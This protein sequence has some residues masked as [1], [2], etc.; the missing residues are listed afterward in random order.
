MNNYHHTPTIQ[1]EMSLEL[2]DMLEH[3][4]TSGRTQ[5]FAKPIIDTRE[6]NVSFLE[7][8][9]HLI[10]ESGIYFDYTTLTNENLDSVCKILRYFNSMNKELNDLRELRRLISKINT[11]KKQKSTKKCIIL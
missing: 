7:E 11:T 8:N 5:V 2:S 3:A 1:E 10:A 4:K 6:L 9:S